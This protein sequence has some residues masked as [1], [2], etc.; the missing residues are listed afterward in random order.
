MPVDS[1][2]RRSFAV[3]YVT[4]FGGEVTSKVAVLLA[5]AYLARVLGPR[6]FGVIELALS[7]TLLV[8]LAAEMGLGSYGARLIETSPDRAA[9]LVPRAG[10]LRL[11]LAVP[12]YLV[13]VALS[14]AYGTD[15][16]GILV[17]YG[18]VVLLTPFN[19]QWVFQGLR[20]M[21]WVAAG[22]LLRY[23]TFAVLV[24]LLVRPGT[25]PRI[26]AAA[27]VAGAVALALFN[28]TVLGWVLGIRADWLGALRGAFKLLREAWFLGASDLA[29]M[30]MWLSPAIVI[31]WIDPSRPEQVAWIAAAVR[32]VIALHTFVWLYFFNLLPNLSRELH[33]GHDA[34]RV[35]VQRSVS[36][37][38]WPACFLAAGG[39]LFAPVLL[40]SVFGEAYDQAVVPFQIV[41]WMIPVTWLSGH[42]RYS[43]IAGGRQDL[44]F[45]ASASAAVTTVVLAV[46]LGRTHGA[47]G[48]AAA[49]L[50][51][52][53][54]NAGV[55][56]SA[57]LR[58]IGT[59]RL[60]AA[61][62]ALVTCAASILIGVA[63]AWVIGRFAAATL[64]CALYALVAASRWDRESLRNA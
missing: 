22:S 52:G 6:D 57:M 3:R 17:V 28:S 38:M 16:G 64:A 24:L 62:P 39:T 50:A 56:G 23:G 20:Q 59:I 29:W 44:D 18:L 60:G 26:V 9:R 35:L 40:T 58:A 43:L 51:A 61:T 8:V 48:V 1:L 32:I 33:T 27:E 4:L 45:A 49:L 46:I 42:F 41:I 10:L 53:L 34:W 36:L 15:G 63:G 47:P 25:D 54:V 14:A 37:S 31:G 19:T 2:R 12:A 7:T 5:F 55:A 11:V 21:Q 13:M 30:A